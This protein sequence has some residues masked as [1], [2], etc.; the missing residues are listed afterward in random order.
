[1]WTADGPVIAFEIGLFGWM[2]PMTFVFF[3]ATRLLG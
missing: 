3:P 1:M 2:S